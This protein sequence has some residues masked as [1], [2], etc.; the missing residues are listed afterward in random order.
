[1]SSLVPGIAFGLTAALAGTVSG[2]IIA[3]FLAPRRF[4]M[5]SLMADLGAIEPRMDW[6]VAGVP[7]VIAI[8][9]VVLGLVPT[10]FRLTRHPTAATLSDSGP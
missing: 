6:I 4:A 9:A 1:M 7:L 5:P 10:A 2:I 8:S 3:V